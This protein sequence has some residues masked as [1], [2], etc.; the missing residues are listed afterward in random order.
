MVATEAGVSL[1]TASAAMQGLDI[2]KPATRERVEKAAKKLDYHPNSAASVLSSLRNRN[3]QKKAF[4]VWLSGY[5]AEQKVGGDWD[6]GPRYA[7]KEA[8]RLGL[9]FAAYNIDHPEDTLRIIREIETRG[10]DGIIWGTYDHKTLPTIPW[11]RFCV[12]ATNE[13]RL[14]E[15]FDIVLSNQFRGTLEL[16]R[17]VKNTGYKRIGICLRNHP[18]LHFDDEVRFGAVS[19]FQHYAQADIEP[20]P[21]LHLVHET[22]NSTE[23]LIAWVKKYKPEVVVGFSVGDLNRLREHGFKIPEDFAYVGLHTTEFDQGTLAGRKHNKEVVP[24]YAVRVLM[25]KMRHG[26]RGLSPH[27][28]ET[29]IIPPILAGASCPDLIGDPTD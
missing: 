9:Q 18:V 23:R 6:S 5:S 28:Q 11:N 8:E 10:C 26:I 27:P 19:A 4:I 2:V 29:E 24:E 25:N 15:G 22:P 21:T 16:L 12:V 13:G 3:S 17:R 20:I 14:K 1:S 7:A